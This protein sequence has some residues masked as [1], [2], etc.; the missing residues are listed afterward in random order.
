[1]SGTE[2]LHPEGS[3]NKSTVIS[4]H[5]FDRPPVIETVLGAQF[6]PLP[7][8][9]N[10]H[11][12]LFWSTLGKDWSLGKDVPPLA[13]AY[14]RFES[15][16]SWAGIGGFSLQLTANPASRLQIRNAVQDRMTQVQNGR[17]HYN[18]LRINDVYPRYSAVFAEFSAQWGK[19]KNFVTDKAL[20][21]IEIDQWE[22][23][24][25]N[26]ILKGTVWDAPRDWSKL[27][28]GLG[29]IETSTP[30]PVETLGIQTSFQLPDQKGR[31]HWKLQNALL[32]EAKPGVNR[33]VLRL[34][35]TARGPVTEKINLDM[36][37]QLGHDAIIDAFVATTSDEAKKFWGY[38]GNSGT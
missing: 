35:L 16:K 23:T 36:G 24:Y 14:E 7:G 34:E 8:L 26:H 21:Q 6:K 5:I 32:A 33:E 28:R 4:K 18:W 37:L 20:G 11:L 15:E 27:F 2:H 30:G 9:T 19:F 13:P 10:G 1:M 17:F 12:G 38:H 29:L 22:V 31:L 25:V 3:P